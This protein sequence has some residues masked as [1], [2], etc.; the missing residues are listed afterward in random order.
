MKLNQSEIIQ[1]LRR[2]AEMT[3]GE[4]GSKAFNTSY[5]SGR[6][7]IRNIELGKQAPTGRDLGN[8]A[9]VMGVPVRELMADGEGAIAMEQFSADGVQ[10]DQRV[11]DTFPGLGDYLNMMNKAVILDDGELIHYI[12]IRLSALLSS[13]SGKDAADEGATA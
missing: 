12:A 3:Q 8:L 13:Q 1:I 6:A 10:V 4:L 5:E 11:L 9:R 2:R 7:K